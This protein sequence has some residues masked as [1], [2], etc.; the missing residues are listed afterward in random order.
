M[1]KL[2]RIIEELIDL[3]LKEY[4]HTKNCELL[5]E[6]LWLNGDYALLEKLRKAEINFPGFGTL[7]VP[8]EGFSPC[9]WIHNL[10]IDWCKIHKIHL[11]N[12]AIEIAKLELALHPNNEK[13]FYPEG[14]LV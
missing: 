12:V 13:T 10:V 11:L 7:I 6:A 14:V 2:E 1:D 4:S 3:L 8:K 5:W 9:N